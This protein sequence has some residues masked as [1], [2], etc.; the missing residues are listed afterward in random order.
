[1]TT[2]TEIKKLREATKKLGEQLDIPVLFIDARTKKKE[3]FEKDCAR[4]RSDLKEFRE[5]LT[6]LNGGKN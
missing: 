1:M 4:L 2:K 3:T 5:S 6:N